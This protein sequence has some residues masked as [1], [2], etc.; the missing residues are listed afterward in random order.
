MALHIR[1]VRKLASLNY[2]RNP[3]ALD[4]WHTNDANNSLDEFTLLDGET[5][6]FH[7]H[8]Q[9]VANMEGLDD[10]V[11]EYDTIA[12][13]S[14]GLRAFVEPRAFKCQPH[15]IVYAKTKRGDVVRSDSTTK[16]NASR[17]LVH[18]WKNHDGVDTRVAWSA[19]CFVLRDT[20]LEAFSSVLRLRGV[21]PGDVIPGDLFEEGDD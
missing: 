6:L 15:G 7:C 13:G 1:I 19:G 9:T 16:A 20:D 2:K 18:D 21:K 17:W 11:H 5:V 4:A 14:F 8:A 10:G 3:P 12:P